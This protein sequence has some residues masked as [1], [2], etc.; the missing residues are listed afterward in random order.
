MQKY[1]TSEPV[2]VDEE[3]Q[4]DQALPKTSSVESPPTAEE[5]LAEGEDD[6]G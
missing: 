6:E 1:G 2:T 5:I 4:P 3:D